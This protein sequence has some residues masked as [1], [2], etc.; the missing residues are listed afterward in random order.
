MPYLIDGHNLIP[1]VG[2]QLDSV[3]DELELIELLQEFARLTRSTLEVY[4]DG[5][6]VGQAGKRRYGR[7]TAIFVSLGSS[8]DAAIQQRLRSLRGNARYWTVVSSDR[9]VQ[10]AAAAAK[11]TVEAAEEFSRR[12]RSSQEKSAVE[13]EA[14]RRNR[15][16]GALPAD[17]VQH[18]LEV[19]KRRRD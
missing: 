11:A 3:D 13:E 6:P 17:E 4:F 12:I 16:D 8:A 14:K 2:L 1:R 19:F 15:E 10:R 9:E 5:A 18:W 7:L